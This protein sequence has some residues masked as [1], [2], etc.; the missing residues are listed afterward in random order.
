MV[1]E[2]VRQSILEDPTLVLDDKD[3]VR[4]LL[5]A[6]QGDG[7]NVVDLRGVLINRLEGKLGQLENT[8]RDVV[9]AA[10]EN[11]AGTH[12]VHRAVLSVLEPTSFAAFL[13]AVAVKLPGIMALDAI[14]ICI[15]GEGV[16]AGQALG[17]KGPTRRTILGLPKGGAEAYSGQSGKGGTGR[18]IL[19][20]TT[21]AGSLIFLEEGSTIMSEAI[22]ELDLG[23]GRLPGLLIFGS[24]DADRFSPDQGTDLM[25]FLGASV[26][27]VLQ[28][29]LD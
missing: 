6:N 16:D 22:L 20:K 10:Y 26:S 23:K 17:P 9:A 28:R 24:R 2:V 5:G 21:R 14:K 19:R 13:H 27:L 8:H 1:K 11:L 12:Q 25:S 15:E 3:V 4:A 18:V 29:W 7:R